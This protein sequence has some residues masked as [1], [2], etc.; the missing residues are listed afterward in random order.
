MIA[1][2]SLLSLLGRLLNRAG[3]RLTSLGFALEQRA[4]RRSITAQ[5]GEPIRKGSLVMIGPDG[6]LYNAKAEKSE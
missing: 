6:K 1:V 4:W 5:A 3:H 2:L